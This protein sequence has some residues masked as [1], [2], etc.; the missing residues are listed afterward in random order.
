[1]VEVAW[2]QKQSSRSIACFSKALGQA[3]KWQ[4]LPRNVCQAVEAPQPSRRELRALSPDEANQLLSVARREE[5]V[6]ADAVIVAVHTGLRMGELLGLRWEDVDLEQSRLTIRRAA[7][8]L[9]RRG[10]LY[11]E[12]KTIRSRRIVPLGATSVNALQRARRRQLEERLL[13]GPAYRDQRLVFSTALGT[14]IFPGNLR[15]AFL[16][17]VASSGVGR[18][19][20][21]D[22]RHTHASLLLARGV[23][24][25]VVSERLGHSGIGITLDVYSHVLPTLQEEAARELDAWLAG[26]G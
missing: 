20:F 11:R 9:P 24:P 23:H 10:I 17:M 8:Y 16:R 19:R 22:L 2:Q 6:F 1:M 13:V 18:L 15:R 7:Q 12:P 4:L 3:V 5:T 26:R 25:K 21:H 14:P